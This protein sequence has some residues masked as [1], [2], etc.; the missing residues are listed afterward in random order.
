MIVVGPTRGSLA[1]KALNMS[2]VWRNYAASMRR[3][4]P[5]SELSHN[6]F[7]RYARRASIFV[8]KRS[9]CVG[10]MDA[11]GRFWVS[12]FAPASRRE[13]VEMLRELKHRCPVGFAVCP[14]LVGMLTRIGFTVVGSGPAYF[15]G[16]VVEKT[17]LVN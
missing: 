16:E 8:F 7:G 12:H 5:G 15:L 1:A 17:I 13:G 10:Q 3:R 6:A 9:A 14:D 11:A 4:R 2:D